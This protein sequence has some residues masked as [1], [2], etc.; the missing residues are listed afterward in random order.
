MARPW[1]I[2]TQNKL[3][4]LRLYLDAF[5]TASTKA[6][7]T[8][9]L[10][11]FAGEAENVDRL[12][13]EAIEGSARIALSVES[14]P[15]TSLRFFETLSKARSLE[16]ALRRDFPGRDFEVLAG[17]CNE[18]VPLEL[19][20][21]K[22]LNWAP[23]FAFI[24]HNAMEAQWRT[25]EALAAFKR[26]D[27]WKVEL[28]CLFSPQQFQRLLRVDGEEVRQQDR[29][30]ISDVFGTTDW[31]HIYRARLDGK[32]PSAARADYLN[33]MRWRMETVLGYKRT[34]SLEVHAEAGQSIYYLIFATDHPA[35]DEIMSS[36]FARAAKEFPRTLEEARNRRRA[37]AQVQQA[38]GSIL[39]AEELIAL[40][41]PIQPGER[42]YEHEPPT[43]PWFISED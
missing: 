2:W 27:K 39:D 8:I 5:T 20:K 31:E 37:M 38:Q 3:D 18:L 4:V 35:G 29:A 11:L 28:F 26:K 6:G 21:L 34:H 13:G 7:E 16:A 33:L 42:F 12:T 41:A 40:D 25:L 43:R 24:D 32:E 10:D 14:P 22:S 36:L 23:T 30:A 17:D 19:E 1:G 9:Y 15:F